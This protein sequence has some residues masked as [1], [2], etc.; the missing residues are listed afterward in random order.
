MKIKMP[1]L[2]AGPHGVYQ[3]GREYDLPPEIAEPMVAGDY[4][5]LLEE[6]PKRPTPKSEARKPA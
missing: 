6:P 5:E 4:A 1:T 2:A 3:A